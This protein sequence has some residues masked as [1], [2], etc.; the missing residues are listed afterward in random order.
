MGRLKTRLC[1]EHTAFYRTRIDDNLEGRPDLQRY[2]T[3]DTFFFTRSRRTFHR[4]SQPYLLTGKADDIWSPDSPKSLGEEIGAVQETGPAWFTLY[5][6]SESINPG[7]GL[8]FFDENRELRG[9][10][11]VKVTG[12]RILAHLTLNG[13]NPG[14]VIFRNHDHD[15][16][17]QLQGV[18]SSRRIGLDLTFSENSEGF[19]LEGRDED[20]ITATASLRTAKAEAQK[21]EAALETMKKQLSKLNDGIFSLTSLTLK[22]RPYFLRTSELNMLR[23]EVTTKLEAARSH[24]FRQTARRTG[25]S[26][27]AVYP[28]RDLDYTHNIS[29]Q[30][31]R[32]FYA[33]NVAVS[34][35]PAV[36]GQRPAKPVDGHE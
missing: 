31:A 2:S 6:K 12:K 18:T 16:L 1:E 5:R 8:C 29:N 20:G 36:E 19:T 34:I 26:P 9:L 32:R 7:D 15:F 30:A 35:E 22:T 14:M 13:L 23:R 17:K 24:S 10:Q 28:L 4:G 25:P 3:P 33:S 21:P 11:V 27:R